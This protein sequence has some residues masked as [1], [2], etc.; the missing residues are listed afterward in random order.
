MEEQERPKKSHKRRLILDKV[1]CYLSGMGDRL[2]NATDE[3]LASAEACNLCVAEAHSAADTPLSAEQLDQHL[4]HSFKQ[5]LQNTGKPATVEEEKKQAHDGP[6]KAD[7]ASTASASATA[8]KKRSR[9]ARG[10]LTA[11]LRAVRKMRRT[12]ASS[13]APFASTAQ[14]SLLAA[15]VTA[16]PAPVA[17]APA[18]LVAEAAALSS[19]RDLVSATVAG[20]GSA[21]VTGSGS[22]TVAGS[23]SASSGGPTGHTCP[24]CGRSFGDRIGQ[25]A[26]GVFRLSGGKKVTFIRFQAFGNPTPRHV[27]QVTAHM[28]EF[29]L[30]ICWELFEKL[31]AGEIDKAQSQLMRQQ[32]CLKYNPTPDNVTALHSTGD[33]VVCV[34]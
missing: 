5:D 34:P 20:S 30:G 23:G 31:V 7:M 19:R 15:P 1:I 16:A 3:F 11:S 21:T 25:T 17:A 28:S 32:L 29:H 9:G 27:I 2:E 14:V 8:K 12:S 6:Q 18:A 33:V 4:T 26:L 10:W 22:A 24:T 13:A